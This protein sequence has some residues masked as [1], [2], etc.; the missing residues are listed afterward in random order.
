MLSLYRTLSLR[1]HQQHWFRAVLV[2]VSIALGVATLVFTRVLNQTLLAAT[3]NAATPLAGAADLSV[4]NSQFGVPLSLR[5]RLRVPGVLAVKP[6]LFEQV[7]IAEGEII[8]TVRIVAADPLVELGEGNSYGVHVDLSSLRVWSAGDKPVYVGNELAPLLAGKEKFHVRT[9]DGRQVELVQAGTVSADGVAATVVGNSLFMSLADALSLLDPQRAGTVTR[10]DLALDPDADREAV[11]QR[12]EA[13]LEGKGEV[14]T[15]EASGQALREVMAGLEMGFSLIGLGA[16]VVGLFLVYNAL[17]VSVAERRHDI[18]V[19]RSLGGTRT[20]IAT[21]F[22]GEAMLL[23]SVGALIGVPVGLGMARLALG[24]VQKML[25]DLFVPLEAGAVT[26][27]LLTLLLSAGAGVLTALLAALV[28]ALHAAMEQPADAVRRNPVV[29][30]W[31]QRTIHIAGVLL[32]LAAG[33]TLFT[34]RDPL[35]LYFPA[36]TGTYGGVVLILLATMLSMPL[37]AASAAWLLRPARR[38]LGIEERLAADNLIRAPGRTGLVIAALAAGVALMVQTAGLIRS[39]ERPILQWVREAIAADLFASRGGPVST[40]G[41]N[42]PMD[43]G[44]PGRMQAAFPNQIEAAL[45]ARFQQLRYRDTIVLL[46]AADALGFYRADSQRSAPVPGLELYPRLADQPDAVLISDNFAAKHGVRVGDWIEVPGN[47]DPVR[48]HVIGSVVD[49]S[50]NHGTIIMDRAQYQARFHDDK[51]DAIDLYLKPGTDIEQFRQTLQNWGK[52]ETLFVQTQD[53]LQERISKMIHQLYGVAMLQELLVGVVSVLGVV[54]ALL[55][56]VLQ[57]RRE[58]GLL[59][60]VGATQTQVLRAVIAEATLMG[61]VGILIG[62]VLGVPL[63]WFVVRIILFEETG[64]LFPTRIPWEDAGV[65]AA[66]ALAA[67]ALAGVGPALHAIR[68]RI[69]EAIAYE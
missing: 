53:E 19:M 7:Q 59:R 38:L 63:E 49:Y 50:W 58:L 13:V 9:A 8:R 22:V 33:V 42:L 35:R 60:A 11:R 46:V 3:R 69:P 18:G 64:F 39:N 54:M 62:I 47:P 14:A 2:I 40:N 44:M 51:V 1:Y 65:I 43:A 12:L 37:L 20:Q 10:F 36:R 27:S 48:L 23:G 68:L 67:A 4:S 30:R 52:D 66:V 17:S 6:R 28:P 25:S 31:G 26:T 45:P 56:S 24:P 41:Q 57:R 34:L 61:A 16:L 5:D 15:P 32:L 29:P 55:I 21:L